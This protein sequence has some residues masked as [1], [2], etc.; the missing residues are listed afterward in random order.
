MMKGRIIECQYG[1]QNKHHSPHSIISIVHTTTPS[2]R[3][4]CFFSWELGGGG[5]G[6]R[7][8]EWDGRWKRSPSTLSFW[9]D[10]TLS[11]FIHSTPS[12]F[13]IHYC[14]RLSTWPKSLYSKNINYD[15]TLHPFGDRCLLVRSRRV[16][17][18]W[19]A[20][21]CCL[22][23]KFLEFHLELVLFMHV[24]GWRCLRWRSESTAGENL[25]PLAHAA[26][27]IRMG[28]DSPFMGRAQHY[29]ITCWASRNIVGGPNHMVTCE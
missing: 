16:C 24:R 29:T 3:V 5:V 23:I 19:Y 6:E 8:D 2:E 7:A 4:V 17:R 15:L 20:T 14:P 22:R 1:W 27:W 25:Q 12:P 9:F 28:M 11:S 18:S 13:A 10:G 26:H 21:R